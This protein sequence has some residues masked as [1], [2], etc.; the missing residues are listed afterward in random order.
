VAPTIQTTE[1][2]VQG[3]NIALV[4]LD[5]RDKS[6]TSVVK[7]NKLRRV[8]ESSFLLGIISVVIV[9]A[10]CVKKANYI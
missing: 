7:V 4:L 10:S 1:F 6:Y 2:R 3:N 8:S 9:G 5:T